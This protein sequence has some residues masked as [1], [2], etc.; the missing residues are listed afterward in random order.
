MPDSHK[1]YYYFYY[2]GERIE[3]SES[4]GAT[5]LGWHYTEKD[6]LSK[7]HLVQ[8][9]CNEP[10]ISQILWEWEVIEDS[11]ISVPQT[12]WKELPVSILKKR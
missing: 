10:E 11:A 7:K 2:N 12:G 9:V 3:Y 5:D 1:L 4:V 8:F 6:I